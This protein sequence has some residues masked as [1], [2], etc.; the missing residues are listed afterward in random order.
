MAY[1]QY[2]PREVEV[3]GEALYAASIRP[4]VEVDHEGEFVVIDIESGEYEIDPD[5]ISATQ[6]LLARRPEAIVYGLRIG[7]SVSYY[8]LTYGT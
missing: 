8:I 6:R 4:N 2:S 3:R 7:H 5:D 1:A